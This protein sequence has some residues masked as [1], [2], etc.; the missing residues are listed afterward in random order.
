M[1]RFLSL[2]L[3]LCTLL[4][5]FPVAISA[6]EGGEDLAPE[7][8]ATYVDLYVKDGLVALF[9]GYSLT[10]SETAPTKWA[11]VNLFGVE[12]YEDY[13]DPST[14]SYY[15]A[16]GNGR[17]GWQ[18]VDGGIRIYL[19]SATTTY[20]GTSNYLNLD[21]LG[22]LLNYTKSVT[23]QEVVS[24]DAMVPEIVDGVMTNY[25]S[26]YAGYSYHKSGDGAIGSYGYAGTQLTGAKLNG[27]DNT[28]GVVVE[29]LAWNGVYLGHL[30]YFDAYYGVA[31]HTTLVGDDATDLAGYYVGSPTT[32]E[33][34]I[35]RHPYTSSVVDGV[36]KYTSTYDFHYPVL[37]SARAHADYATSTGFTKTTDDEASHQSTKL[38]LVAD[39]ALT[40]SVRVYNK[41]LSYAEIQQNRIA[42]FVGYY[43]IGADMIESI[44]AFDT[45][46]MNTLSESLSAIK[47]VPTMDKTDGSAYMV[48]KA[49]VEAAIEA[50]IEAVPAVEDYVS[51]YV[52]DGLVAL[53]DFY[54]LTASDNA[55]SS[56]SPVWLYEAEGYEDYLMPE[57]QALTTSGKFTWKNGDGYLQLARNDGATGDYD[58]YLTLSKELSEAL[59]GEFTVQEVFKHETIQDSKWIP[60]FDEENNTVTNPNLAT[61]ANS[62][63]QWQNGEY[64]FF[65]VGHTF[66]G[67]NK[68]LK[69]IFNY[70]QEAHYWGGTWKKSLDFTNDYYYS[71]NYITLGA[72][73]VDANGVD[74]SN[75]QIGTG[76]LGT[77]ERSIMFSVEEAEGT[78]TMTATVYHQFAVKQGNIF[79][80]VQDTTNKSEAYNTTFKI[81]RTAA[82][83]NYSI[84]LYNK[85]LNEGELAQNHLADLIA[86]Y[87]VEADG[88]ATLPAE[89][90][91]VVGERL[92]TLSLNAVVGTEEYTAGAELI[93]TTVEELGDELGVAVEDAIAFGGVSYRTSGDYGVRALFT[94]DNEAIALI[95]KCGFTVVYGAVIYAG[96]ESPELGIDEETGKLA[97]NGKGALV[98]TDAEG[99]IKYLTDDKVS[100]ATTVTFAADGSQS[101]LYETQ[102]G[103]FA[104]ILVCQ[105]GMPIN[106][107][108]DYALVENLDTISLVSVHEYVLAN[109]ADLTPE[110]IERL[111]AVLPT[112]E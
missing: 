72:G 74:I 76:A 30:S 53:F 49:A 9:D 14:Y 78:Y 95:E 43:G 56:I 85:V 19:K 90:L 77:D 80:L 112:E 105:D 16:N 100:F 103:Y 52:K 81:M 61:G 69:S 51:L 59:A 50:A 93:M 70:Y 73:Y 24:H 107:A 13:I 45:F 86:Y 63:G 23:V 110:L 17:Y 101:A 99:G 82:E 41:A 39:G 31:K 22:A 91:A 98:S 26:M 6:V 96:E 34:T 32:V 48:A 42:D 57:T 2:F 20:W 18:Q 3:V 1:K 84:R 29:Q 27:T 83:I 11:P 94:V 62:I 33:R 87:G 64:G 54:S 28:V 36:T 92:A 66:Y 44:L 58:A 40:R 106:I 10:A 5:L 88:L 21:S 71:G 75:A 8:T 104:F 109:E 68:S 89:L 108:V 60:I 15:F 67:V 55:L 7:A 35:I 4:C 12:G 37:P 25:T 47:L 38:R 97:L 111:E 65:K 102:L 79:T 46:K